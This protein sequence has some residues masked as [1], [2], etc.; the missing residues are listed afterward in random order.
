[1][2]SFEIV[3][4]LIA[5]AFVT[6]ITPGPNN[7]MLMVSGINFGFRRTVPHMLG[8]AVGMGVMILSIGIGLKE[9]FDL[10][11]ISYTVLKI[12]SMIFLGYLSWKIAMASSMQIGDLNKESKPLN[13]IQAAL[14]QWVNPK[15]WIMSVT[16]VSAYAPDKTVIGMIVVALVFVLISLPSISVWA[17][18]GTQLQ[19]ILTNNVKLK[20][21][22]ISAAILLILS[23]YPVLT[24]F[25][26]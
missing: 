18:L 14:F 17:Y 13:F 20:I 10:F 4:A 2:M 3:T 9:V 6:T 1:M 16:A 15:A 12:I 25:D 23:L 21:F 19:K 11:P 22:N 5:F 24:N 26:Y 8:I 7:L